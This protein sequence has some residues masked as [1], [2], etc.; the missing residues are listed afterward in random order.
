MSWKR[1]VLLGI[2]ALTCTA[3]ASGTILPAGDAAGH[4][5]P[6]SIDQGQNCE[7]N[8][9]WYERAAGVCDRGGS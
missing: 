2:V 3:C 9:G 5:S 4:A 7:R 8:G 6:L 1:T